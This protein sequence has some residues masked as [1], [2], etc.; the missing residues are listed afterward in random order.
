[1]DAIQ[2]ESVFLVWRYIFIFCHMS[3]VTIKRFSATSHKIKAVIYGGSGTW[4]T[5]FWGS[6]PKPIFASAEGGLLSISHLNP[7]YVEIKTL[8][9]LRWLLSFLR[10]NKWDYETVVID[11]IT[12][13][14]E[15][16]KVG[17]ERK[18]GRGM[19][20]QDYG[21][22]SKTIRE[23]L[24]GF[25]DLDMHVVF[26]AQ[27]KYEKDGDKIEKIVPSLN[28]KSADEIAYFMDVVWYIYLDPST[29]ERRV[30][31]NTNSK[32][33]SKD[34]T[35]KIGNNTEPD[36]KQWIEAVKG[37]HIIKEQETVQS[38]SEP[39]EKKQVSEQEPAGTPEI[40][41]SKPYTAQAA[42]IPAI[43]PKQ[44]Q[45]AMDIMNYLTEWVD[46]EQVLSKVKWSIF[47]SCGVRLKADSIKDLLSQL[48][49]D[50]ATKLIEFLK[51]RKEVEMAKRSK[52]APVQQ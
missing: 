50:Q 25:R 37:L 23:I 17:I 43:S 34:R 13:I 4:K 10:N 33:L 52:Q 29:G 40:Q 18:S 42:P 14:S 49:K 12:E 48:D 39:E 21:T 19:Q 45:F 41:K 22:L 11:S 35:G 32:T 30:I 27:E 36:F 3:A 8:D 47:S 26:I 28:G 5:T 2:T 46:P 6:C 15:I 31:T 7:D 9:D 20:F 51:L 38:Y 24:R 1:M 44:I 16:I